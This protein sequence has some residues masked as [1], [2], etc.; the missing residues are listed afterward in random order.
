MPRRS[1]PYAIIRH[2][3]IKTLGNLAAAYS[4]IA[5]ELREFYSIGYY[6]ANER[7]AGKRAIVKV[8]TNRP[9]TV[10]RAREGYM[11]RRDRSKR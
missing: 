3:K 7:V 9:G 11:I 1:A 10:V 2:A 4:K 8:K 6:P 5:S